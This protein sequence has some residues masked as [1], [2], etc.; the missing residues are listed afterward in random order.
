MNEKIIA[1]LFASGKAVSVKTLAKFLEMSSGDVSEALTKLAKELNTKT[2]A[3]HVLVHEGA[4]QL[5]TNPAYSELV[6]QVSKEEV[7]GELTRPQ[8]ETLAIICYRAPVTKPEIEQIRGVNCSLIIR[9]LL[10]RGLIEER[11]DTAKLQPVYSASMDFLRHL[12]IGAMSALPDY[13]HFHADERIS[14]LLTEAVV[15]EEIERH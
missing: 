11:D 6:S 2:S 7:S 5:V 4:V 13:E 12:G 8:L 3:V 10:M 9:N 14:K 1:I 15:P